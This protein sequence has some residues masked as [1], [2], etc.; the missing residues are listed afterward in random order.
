[1]VLD[2]TRP[3]DRSVDSLPCRLRRERDEGVSLDNRTI[4]IA[5][6]AVA[7]FA[8]TAAQ[9]VIKTR[10][11]AH[12]TVPFTMSDS[13]PYLLGI[14]ADWRMWAGLLGL[15]ASSLFWYTA[16]SRIPLSLAF[17]MAAMSYPLVCAGAVLF[18]DEP[19]RWAVL[20]GNLLIVTGVLVVASVSH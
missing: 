5:L 2:R 13:L 14:I 7:V 6:V 1:M 12:G 20:F 4:G 11:T 10:L 17:P 16:V 9:L 8:L 19:F 3:G 15:I 18:L